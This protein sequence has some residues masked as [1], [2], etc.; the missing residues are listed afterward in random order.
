MD[1]TSSNTWIP[2]FDK[3]FQA[4]TALKANRNEDG[5]MNWNFVEADVYIDLG[6]T[7]FTI[8]V[9]AINDEFDFSCEEFIFDAKAMNKPV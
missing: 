9:D 5:T 1:H 7:D 4:A 2:A 6:K 8:P 3:A